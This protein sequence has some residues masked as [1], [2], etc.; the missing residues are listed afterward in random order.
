MKSAFP[1]RQALAATGVVTLLFA[2]G[3][4]LAGWGLYRR[5]QATDEAAALNTVASITELKVSQITRWREERLRDAQYLTVDPSFADQ[6]A[7]VSRAPRSP[8]APLLQRR[9]RILFRNP[10]YL[11]AVLL[12]AAGTAPLIPGDEMPD[13]SCIGILGRASRSAKPTLGE[14][15]RHVPAGRLH[16][17]VVAPLIDARGQ[18]L[19]FLVTQ[20][21]PSRFLYPALASWP[22]PSATAETLLVRRDG[23][24]IVFL[25]S[26]RH[27]TSGPLEFRLSLD[28]DQHA[29]VGLTDGSANLRGWDYRGVE[30][31][32]AVRPV[33][34]TRWF[35]I[36]KLDVAE[37]L[38]ENRTQTRLVVAGLVALVALVGATVGLVLFF[39]RTRFYRR[40]YAETMEREAMLKQHASA[41]QEAEARVRE[42]N[43]RLRLAVFG[44][45]TALY[46][47]DAKLRYTWVYN[48]TG[49]TRE[50]MVGRTDE[51]LFGASGR[52][53]AALKRAVM[54]SRVPVRQ[55]LELQ[56]LGGRHYYD[57]T[58]E[59]IVVDDEVIGVR[60]VANDVTER[61][62]LE[63][64]LRQAQ[65]LE[66]VGQLA[67]G[68]AHDFNNLLTAINGYTELALSDTRQEDKRRGDLIE[69]LRAGERAAALTRQLLAF[70]RKQVLQ[71]EPVDVNQL[72]THTSWML[73][74]II[75]EHIQLDLSLCSEATVYADRGQLEQV[76]LNLCVNAR[77]AMEGGGR[78]LI[79]TTQTGTNGNSRVRILVSDTGAGIPPEI[80]PHIFEPFFTTKDRGKGTGLGL[81]TVY[82]IVQQSGGT[83]HVQSRV[84][85]G[86]TFTIEFP[87]HLGDSVSA[88]ATQLPPGQG[89]ERILI[90]EDDPPVRLLAEQVLTRAGYHVASAATIDEALALARRDRF[91]LLLT[92]VVMPEMDGCQLAERVTAESPRT[93]VLF[94][95]GYA[96]TVL[97]ERGVSGA[98]A[99][100]QKPFSALGLTNAVRQ[101]LDS[102]ASGSPDRTEPR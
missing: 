69:V 88:A 42:S 67:G 59:A 78:I 71:P 20:I 25:N 56:F 100:L 58:I 32:A 98:P 3:V 61:H 1:G 36:S 22:V 84:G 66:A 89:T 95:S 31:L 55:E 10:E 76:L 29:P 48:P 44:T 39:L 72:I 6:I 83:I 90:V 28:T 17:D 35:V 91:D 37:A 43:E 23:S 97:A 13:R 60:G 57:L 79:A 93:R 18:R 82:G 75:G 51:E 63:D 80:L 8:I 74:R 77:D 62:L 64:Q 99:L 49:L 96:A 47:Q 27:V 24:H 102:A 38:A 73:R 68:V 65:K 41:L 30:V 5:D 46:I 54:A 86:T 21:D 92:D 14:I 4:S 12:N 53:L 85:E 50:A 45:S 101:A 16:L 87:S 26:P 94:M 2:A 33:P 40:Q 7:E 19:A 81:A 70:S 34:G 52:N 15:E 9:V 11:N